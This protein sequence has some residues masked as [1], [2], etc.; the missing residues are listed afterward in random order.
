M[1]PSSSAPPP[2]T[3]LADALGR[4]LHSLRI[5]V[6]DR[7]D[8]RCHYCMPEEHYTWLPT[9]DILTFD[10]LERIAAVFAGLGVRRLRL[11]G[12]EP[13]LRPRLVELVERLGRIPGVEDLALT[14]NATHLAEW[15]GPLRQAGLHRVTASLDSLRPDRFER[16][17]RRRAL[18]QV[19]AGIQAAS[20]AGYL[21]L[22]IN[23]VVVRGLNDDELVDLV[24]FGRQTGAEVRFIEY[25]DVGGATRWSRDAVVPRAEIIARLEARYGRAEPLV[26]AGN[27]PAERFRL[28][29][30]TRFGIVAS[31]TAP[32][33]R[34]CDRSRLT[35][36]GLW[37]LCLY[38]REGVDLR[39]LVRGE[40]VDGLAEEIER[41]WRGR[42]N[43]GA[44]ERA[45]DPQRGVLFA[46]A[47]LQQDPHREMHTRGG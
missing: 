38:A 6:I 39:R 23:C 41:V 32:F 27:A 21:A 1:T 4:R 42:T 25:M 3:D 31:V 33:C 35:A 37:F 29:D 16:L 43:R 34:S 8:L 11:T 26:E 28:A 22:K 12:G 45:E 9:P 14:T 18:D 13:L 10:E 30:G 20:K 44:E 15:A 47:D 17:T 19:V 7:C 46:L 40:G 2:A 24:E 36:D 5:S